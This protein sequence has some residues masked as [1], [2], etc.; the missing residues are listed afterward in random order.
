MRAADHTCICKFV[1]FCA[2]GPQ[3]MTLWRYCSRG[4]LEVAPPETL[5]RN[6]LYRKQFEN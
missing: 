1:G 4:S 3:L 5:L 2:D 6:S